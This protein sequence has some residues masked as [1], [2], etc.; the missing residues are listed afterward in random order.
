MQDEGK[1]PHMYASEL[2]GSKQTS[3]GL[4]TIEWGTL[5]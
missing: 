2:D 4:G 3:L 5:N 1:A